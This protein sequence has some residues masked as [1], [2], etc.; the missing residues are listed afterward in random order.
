[1]QNLRVALVCFLTAIG[2]IWMASTIAHNFGRLPTMAFIAIV[3][4]ITFNPSR[5]R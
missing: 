3:A 5:H 1:M 4:L 2:L